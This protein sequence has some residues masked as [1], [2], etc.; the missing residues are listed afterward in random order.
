MAANSA[1]PIVAPIAAGAANY[2]NMATGGTVRALAGEEAS[3]ALDAAT[4][5]NPASSLAGQV[6]G[7]VTGALGSQAALA[8]R[9]PGFLAPYADKA[10]DTIFGGLTGF[11]EA[12]EGQ[13]LTGAAWGAGAGLAGS[14]GGNLAGKGLSRI[15]MPSEGYLSPAERS[16][17]GVV[18][19]DFT[20]I[21]PQFNEAV[22]LNVPLSLADADPRLR[23]LGGV[24]TRKSVNAAAG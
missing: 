1:N 21:C 22:R 24:A 13:G 11:N 3:G 8:G 14:F 6:L 20:Q 7:G 19:G 23:A 4:A 16:I 17:A 2:A 9:L 12:G 10:A 15:G 18:K 5:M